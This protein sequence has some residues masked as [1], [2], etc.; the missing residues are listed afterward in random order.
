V[1]PVKM[2]WII[3]KAKKEREGLGEIEEVERE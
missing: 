2:D 1:H 3:H